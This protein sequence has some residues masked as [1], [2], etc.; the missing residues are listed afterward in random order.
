MTELKENKRLNEKEL[1]IVGKRMVKRL[2]KIVEILKYF[3]RELDFCD[4]NSPD[5]KIRE[6]YYLS[7]IEKVKLLLKDIDQPT[8]NNQ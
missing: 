8:S 5:Y 1:E 4:V 2:N 3:K 7:S 6:L